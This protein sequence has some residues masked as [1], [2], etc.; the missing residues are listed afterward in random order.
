[1]S[2]GQKNVLISQVGARIMDKAHR[3]QHF[4]LLF[5]LDFVN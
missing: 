1:M 5:G 4:S 3:T 2:K